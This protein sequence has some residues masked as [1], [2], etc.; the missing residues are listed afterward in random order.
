MRQEL[1]C[2]H[3]QHDHA[4]CGNEDKQ[5]LYI[6]I[7]NPFGLSSFDRCGQWAYQIKW[8]APQYSFP[9]GAALIENL[10]IEEGIQASFAT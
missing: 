6:G 2:G 3:V 4:Y 9:Q 10:A 1:R 5:G 8:C 7:D